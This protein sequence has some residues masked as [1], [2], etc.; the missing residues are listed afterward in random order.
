MKSNFLS[1]WYVARTHPHAETKA[2]RHLG[3]QGF[4]F[5]LPR[6]LKKR[7]HARRV[8]VVP[9][10]L[11]PGYIF[12][13]VDH[14]MQRWQPI[15]STIGIT[16]IMCSGDQPAAVPQEVVEELMRREDEFGMIQLE[17]RV[18]F[19]PGDTVRVVTGAFSKYLG[20]YEGADERERVA[21]LLSLLG[22][23]V[24]VHLPSEMVEA[25]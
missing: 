18:Q 17:R 1:R 12:V 10:P 4:E 5:Y 11:Y 22:R 23:K 21:I 7:R 16:R 9:R 3:R 20:L 15:Q 14:E 19:K 2:A 6:Y 13:A 8:E 24:R 25:A